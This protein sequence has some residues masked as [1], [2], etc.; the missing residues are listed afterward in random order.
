[1]R[2]IQRRSF[3]LLSTKPT[4][5]TTTT[6]THHN[7]VSDSSGLERNVLDEH[8]VRVSSRRSHLFV[9]PYRTVRRVGIIDMVG[10]LPIRS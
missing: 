6:T 7:D 9:D 4:K 5:P 3:S 8:T 10:V 2:V 1:M